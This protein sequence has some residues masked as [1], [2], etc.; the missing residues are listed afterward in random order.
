[1]IIVLETSGKNEDVDN[2]KVKLFTN[3]IDAEK[4]CKENTDDPKERKYWTYCEIIQEGS[5]YEVARYCNYI[6]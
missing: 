6:F 3:Q 2:V 4:Y 1:M 5:N